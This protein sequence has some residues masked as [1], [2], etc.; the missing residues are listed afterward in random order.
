M[1]QLSAIHSARGRSDETTETAAARPTQKK[2]AF[3]HLQIALGLQK[4]RNSKTTSKILAG[5][6]T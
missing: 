1:C 4:G 6:R 3:V 5:P 2:P